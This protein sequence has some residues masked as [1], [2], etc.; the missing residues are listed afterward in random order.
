MPERLSL[1][2]CSPFRFSHCLMEM[3]LVCRWKRFSLRSEQVKWIKV[4]VPAWEVPP[5]PFQPEISSFLQ[6]SQQAIHSLFPSL[7]FQLFLMVPLD[8]KST[9]LNSSHG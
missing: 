6:C 3:A 7:F 5:P 1:P 8:R 4:P 2:S 9:R